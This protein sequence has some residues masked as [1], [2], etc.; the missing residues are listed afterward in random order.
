MNILHVIDIMKLFK[1]YLNHRFI[2]II[3]VIM[4]SD[5]QLDFEENHLRQIHCLNYASIFVYF[6]I[7]ANF[8]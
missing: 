7:I 6:D 1:Q 4:I 8:I 2:D 5:I 3:I